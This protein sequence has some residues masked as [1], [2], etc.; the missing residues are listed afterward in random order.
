MYIFSVV[1]D[2]L[3]ELIDHKDVI[4]DLKFAPDGSMRL[5][6]A[7]RDGTLKLWEMNDDGN[8]SKTMRGTGK[9]I[10]SCAWSPD[11]KLLCS[12]GD[13]RSV[14]NGNQ[15]RLTSDISFIV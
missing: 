5:I 9:W 10:Y 13:G 14:S 6:S 11:A 7:S 15:I 8:M 12:V 3:L 1:G 4:R 2:L